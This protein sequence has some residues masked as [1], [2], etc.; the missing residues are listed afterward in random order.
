MGLFYKS[1][2]ER[3]ELDITDGVLQ[4]SLVHDTR[5]KSSLPKM[6]LPSLAK[7]DCASV[8]SVGFPDGCT[9]AIFGIWHRDE[10]DMIWHQA[11]GPD[12]DSVASSRCR[13]KINIVRV[14]F[15][16]K[17]SALPAVASLRYMVG[18]AGNY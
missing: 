15:F 18:Q 11:I 13:H 10:M 7:I 16:T 12:I 4:I 8:V 2:S 14:V 1:G 17:K 3:I 6:P 9:Q 5:I